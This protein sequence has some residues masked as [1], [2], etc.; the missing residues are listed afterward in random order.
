M[1]VLSDVLETYIQELCT[2]SRTYSEG[3]GRT[4]VNAED[5]VSNGA[6]GQQ[7]WCTV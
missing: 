6:Q 1:D 5:L 7:G 2:T 3:A 4:E